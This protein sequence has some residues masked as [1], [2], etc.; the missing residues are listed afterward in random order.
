MNHPRT[1]GNHQHLHSSCQG[2][3]RESK[4]NKID[5]N[6]FDGNRRRYQY[7]LDRINAYRSRLSRKFVYALYILTVAYFSPKIFV[8][9][10][11]RQQ[12]FLVSNDM[13]GSV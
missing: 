8:E 7:K 9:F 13:F 3:E 1:S 10:R 12:L 11:I 4:D 6:A 5:R 2:P